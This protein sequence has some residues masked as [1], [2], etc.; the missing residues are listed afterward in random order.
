MNDC[1]PSAPTSSTPSAPC[2][3]NHRIGTYTREFRADSQYR[4]AD[5]TFVLELSSTAGVVTNPVSGRTSVR[6]SSADLNSSGSTENIGNLVHRATKLQDISVSRYVCTP[7]TPSSPNVQTTCDIPVS[8]S[9]N[10]IGVPWKRD[11]G[12]LRYDAAPLSYEN[13]GKI[14]VALAIGD[15]VQFELWSGTPGAAGATLLDRTPEVRAVSPDSA[16]PGQITLPDA[17]PISND[18]DLPALHDPTVGAVAGNADVSGGAATYT[19]PIQVPPGRSGMQPSVSLSYSSRAGNGIAGLGWNLGAGSSISRCPQTRA[20]DGATRGVQFDAQDRLCLDGQRLMKKVSTATYGAASTEYRT[21]IDSFARITQSAAT[22]DQQAVCF[23]VKHKDGRTLT[24]GCETSNACPSNVDAYV[25]PIGVAGGKELSWLLNR[26]EDPTGNTMDYCYTTGGDASEVLLDR[27]LYTGSTKAGVAAAIAQPSRSVVFDYEA[28]PFEGRGNDHGSSWIGGGRVLQTRRLT[29]IRT[30][31]PDSTL[32]AR[33]YALN[34][35]DTAV[36]QLQHSYYSGRSLLRRVSECA[37]D[38]PTSSTPNTERCLPATQFTWTDGTW[39]FTSRKL[40]A[41]T[42][43]TSLTA[44]ETEPLWTDGVEHAAAPEYRRRTV[45]PI[46]DLDGDGTRETLVSTNWYDGQDW[47]VTSQLS[48]ITADRVTKGAVTLGDFRPGDAVDI[49][50]DGVSEL[51]AAGKIYKWTRGRGAA[52]CDGG[53]STCSASAGSYFQQVDTNLAT[54]ESDFVQSMADFNGDGAPDVLIRRGAGV[55]CSSGSGSSGKAVEPPSGLA[56]LCLYLNTRPGPIV[57]STTTYNFAAPLPIDTVV[58]IGDEGVQHVADLDGNGYADIVISNQFGVQRVLRGYASGTGVTFTA[59]LPTQLGMR[60]YT[61]NLRWMDVNADGLDDMV[62]ADVPGATT[63][64]CDTNGNCYAQWVLQI[65][66]GNGSFAEQVYPSTPAG[67]LSPGLSI[68]RRGGSAW[69]LRYYS[70]MIQTDVDSDGR[71]DLLYP[72]RFAARMC[73]GAKVTEGLCL[74][75]PQE[76]CS[77]GICDA[78]VCA[79]PPP[80]DGAA[81]VQHPNEFAKLCAADAYKSGLGD[82]DPSVYRYNAIRFVQ[83][84]D[85]GYRLQIDE[86]PILAGASHLG[87]QRGRVDD[88]FGDGL[89]DIVADAGCP[90]LPTANFPNNTCE[91]SAGDNNGPGS[92]TSYLDAAQTIQLGQLVD[93]ANINL[94]INENL[95]DGARPAL[96]PTFPD[97]MVRAINGLNDRA[98]WDYYPLSSGAGR[99]GTDFPLYTI[100]TGYVDA[101]HFLFQSTMPVVSMLA[102]SNG[103]LSG[104]T[105]ISATGLRSLRYSYSGAMYNSAGRGFQGFRAIAS[106]TIGAADRNV[107]TQTTFH[108]KFPLTGRIESVETRVPQVA[109]PNGRISFET[110][111]WHCDRNDRSQSCPGQN[112]DTLPIE[113]IYWPY[114]G[115]STKQTFDLAKAETGATPLTVST[116]TTINGDPASLVSGWDEYGN[117]KH[118]RVTVQDGT[119]AVDNEHYYLASHVTTTVNT[120]LTSPQL[121][122]DWWLDKLSESLTQTSLTYHART[123][124]SGISL[125]QK[126]VLTQFQW[127]DDRTPV[128]STVTDPMSSVALT[129]TYGYPTPSI[130]LP[131]SVT[132]SGTDVAPVR[133]TRTAYST[134]GHFPVSV[135]G[136]LSASNASLNHM[137]STTTRASDGQPTSAT[138][139]NGIQTVREYDAFGRLLVTSS[140]G[141][142]GQPLAPPSK[143]RLTSCSPCS[144]NDEFFAKYY[145]STVS[146]GTPSQRAWF[147]ILGRE[148][149]RAS[150]GFD[151]RWVNVST[152]YDNSGTVSQT[153]APYFDAETPLYTLMTYDR[154]GRPTTKRAPVAELDATQGDVITR[155]TYEGLE[156]SIDVKPVNHATAC[157]AKPHLC[158]TMSRQHN[159]LGQLMRTTDAHGG[160][161]DYWFNPQGHAAAL[162]DANGKA[163]LSRYNSFGH[164]T[165]S[166]DP[167]QGVWSFTYNAL[168]EL[169]SQTDARGVVTT[170][171]QRD[172]LGRLLSQERVPPAQVPT[173][174]TDERVLDT[175]AYDSAGV[176]GQLALAKRQRTDLQNSP[177]QWQESYNYFLTSGRLQSRTTSIGSGPLVPLINQYQYDKTYGYLKGVTYPNSPQPLTVWRRY[178]RYGA[179]ASL[180]DARLMTP[181]WSM[182]QADAYGKP[183]REQFGYALNG[184]TAYARS[185]GQMLGQTWQPFDEPAFIG[186]IESLDSAMTCSATWPRRSASGGVTNSA[187]VLRTS[188][189]RPVTARI[190]KGGPKRAISTT[191]CSACS[192]SIVR[193]ARAPRRGA[194]TVRRCSRI[195]SSSTTRTT[196]S[197]TSWRNPTSRTRIPMVMLRPRRRWAEPASPPPP[198]APAVR[199]L[200]A[201]R[202]TTTASPR[203]HAIATATS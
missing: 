146:D 28:R 126:K 195:R 183:T 62:I 142:D 184:Q 1:T 171:L 182:T 33:R 69:Q 14:N 85:G 72:A 199:T 18:E 100:D 119:G 67:M 197:A 75:Q 50:G 153:S 86:T 175:W 166:E 5:T 118:Q 156:T 56:P 88:Y 48:K 176:K 129:T 47:H 170:A 98:Q 99:T 84:A 179:L 128:S 150:R 155:Y 201:Q 200:C 91:L 23:T 106:E 53:A 134:D 189:F 194:S 30:F 42:T 93:P 35:E 51:Y 160:R 105:G 174:L 116:T 198:A 89:A 54:G 111:S 107:R 29:G 132:V 40:T 13:I 17:V 26:V 145:Q 65:N 24:Y 135:T 180:T 188:L 55:A 163:T 68:D 45:R 61:K 162:R 21:E 27:I 173:G 37:Y 117:L 52:A 112:G 7:P 19:I 70:K 39:E 169:K 178:T 161:T 58:T 59:A 115:S 165:L 138:D 34:Y 185:T 141:N 46:G 152:R 101:K 38:P 12:T 8:W 36:S 22:L 103:A 144:A 159:A 167:N 181:L 143:S 2:V 9:G 192:A 172:G 49:D 11:L 140:F 147:D 110:L 139:A 177:V 83:T 94:V 76:S 154:L 149:K 114:L 190:T 122:T 164:R 133:E 125:T 202:K 124:P 187:A 10:G 64:L 90:L 60:S 77:E 79:A 157:V 158:L 4:T 71:P 74:H 81:F 168:G 120:Y 137:A 31:S 109:G 186:N 3:S 196:R 130:G 66:K 95:G 20:Q 148:V 6:L 102:R 123:L 127:N 108:Q 121:V 32:P 203:M 63:N 41:S 136:V 151:G 44:P 96:A 78:N 15:R 97:L 92:A 25:R 82:V 193:S 16:N 57:P 191:T 80:E 43:T 131:T 87:N 113:T 104:N 73:F